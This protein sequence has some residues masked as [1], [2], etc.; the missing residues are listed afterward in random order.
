MSTQTNA[1]PVTLHF[2]CLANAAKAL[3]VTPPELTAVLR[4]LTPVE[5]RDVAELVANEG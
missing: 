4:E 2:V 3:N 5:R 1:L